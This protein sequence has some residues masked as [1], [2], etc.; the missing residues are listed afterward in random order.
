MP[1]KE[2]VGR[3]IFDKTEALIK[4]GLAV[5]KQFPAMIAAAS[6]ETLENLQPNEVPS[7]AVNNSKLLNEWDEVKDE[8]RELVYSKSL[9][10][11]GATSTSNFI[12]S[13]VSG[14]HW[15]SPV[16][17][18][19]ALVTENGK[20]AFRPDESDPK[21]QP[22]YDVA[23]LKQWHDANVNELRDCLDFLR[24]DRRKFDRKA[25]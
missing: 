16:S 6:R 8:L 15:P 9:Y 19:Y 22:V 2:V 11:I 5:F 18:G 17:I 10:Q 3:F 1:Q 24:K 14:G 25:V 4:K 23:K 13:L 21:A 12:E 7:R 20:I